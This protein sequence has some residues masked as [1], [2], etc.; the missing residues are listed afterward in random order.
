MFEPSRED[1]RLLRRALK[2][3]WDVPVPLRSKIIEVLGGIVGDENAK[4]RERTAAA[5]A[6]MSAA[7]LE[8]DAIRVAQG[9][10]YEDLVARM[11]AMEGKTD[12]GLAKAEGGDGPAGAPPGGPGA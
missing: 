7:R 5:R 10:Q 8:L 1:A 12:A 11:D 3:G 9:T 6:V 2:Q 4:A